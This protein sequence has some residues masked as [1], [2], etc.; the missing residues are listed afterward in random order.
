M[1]FK[2]SKNVPMPIRSEEG[3]QAE[4]CL[5]KMKSGDSVLLDSPK[6]YQIWRDRARKIELKISRRKTSKGKLRIWLLAEITTPK[7]IL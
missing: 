4:L 6:E 5:K 2:I 7:R 1:K 3:D